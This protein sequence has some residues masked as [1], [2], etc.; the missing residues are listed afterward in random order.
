[1]YILNMVTDADPGKKTVVGF[2]LHTETY[3]G[4]SGGIL[5]ICLNAIFRVSEDSH[6]RLP[7]CIGQI[8][9][10]FFFA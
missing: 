2:R 3:N 7:D 8:R 4:F 9:N 1:M 6:K 5:L 10:E